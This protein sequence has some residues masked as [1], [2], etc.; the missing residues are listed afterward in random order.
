LADLNFEVWKHPADSPDLAPFDY[1]LFPNFKGREFL[2][3][4]EAMLAAD[5]WLA[6]HPKEFF[7]AG[8]KKLE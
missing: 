6:A 2:S 5:R 8:L 3:N 4:E 1:C 7:L